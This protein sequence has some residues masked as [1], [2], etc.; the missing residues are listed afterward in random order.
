MARDYSSTDGYMVERSETLQALFSDGGNLPDFTAFDPNLDA[1]FASD[2]QDAIDAAVATTSGETVDDQV[3]QLTQVVEGAMKNCRKK[4]IEVKYFFNLAFPGNV[5]IMKE[6]GLDD[7]EGARNRQMRLIFFSENLHEAAEKNKIALIAAGYSQLRIDEIVTFVNALRLANKNQNKLLKGRP[8]LT[9]ERE[10]IFN[11]CYGFTK[12]VCD[13]ALSVYYDDDVKAGL[14]VFE[15]SGS[16]NS[17]FFE[18]LIAMNT[19]KQVD[20]FTYNPNIKFILTNTG[21]GPLEFQLKEAGVFVGNT[22]MVMPGS[23]VEKLASEFFTSGDS[24]WVRNPGPAEGSYEIE[25]TT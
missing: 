19:E 16:S 12:R 13:A 25:E 10:K 24:I 21:T 15:P 5:G 23:T 3:I 4:Y 8:L 22:V 6:M 17:E 20:G 11:T 14:F 18:G 7:Y 9:Q 2:W 1:G